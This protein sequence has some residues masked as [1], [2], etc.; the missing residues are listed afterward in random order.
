M[1]RKLLVLAAV[2][3]S[4]QWGISHQAQGADSSERQTLGLPTTS[5][6]ESAH[7]LATRM[8]DAQVR[9][10]LIE[11]LDSDATSGGA[12]NHSV[13]ASAMTG[14]AGGIHANA[15][16]IRGRMQVLFDA[17]LALPQTLQA[18]TERLAGSTGY[19][20][21]WRLAAYLAS[22]LL[23][24]WIAQRVYDFSLRRYRASLACASVQTFFALA[25]RRGIG[26]LLTLEVSP[27]L[28]L[29]RSFCSSPDGWTTSCNASSSSRFLSQS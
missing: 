21:L 27:H 5:S 22:M 11:E 9:N 10:L 24:G 15:S 12:A 17:L 18:V 23:S 4:F 2:L 13:K 25:L 1:N 28:A 8:P 16:T 7:E 29:A 19:S 20:N 26:F 6:K 3:L 14:V